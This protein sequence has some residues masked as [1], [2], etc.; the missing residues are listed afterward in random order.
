MQTTN[1]PAE[2][3]TAAQQA[4]QAAISTAR[5]AR[6]RRRAQPFDADAHYYSVLQNIRQAI[7]AE[8]E[9]DAQFCREAGIDKFNLSKCWP[10]TGDG[11]AAPAKEMSVGLYSRI[12]LALG[13]LDNCEVSDEQLVMDSSLRDYLLVNNF[14]I[15]RSMT[16]LNELN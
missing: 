6:E 4:R 13:I 5:A 14:G 15:V 11:L 16:A 7:G 1:A 10:K 2:I 9:S 3:L 12:C 8:Y